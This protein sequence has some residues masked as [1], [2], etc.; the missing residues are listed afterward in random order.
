[1]KMFLTF[2]VS[3]LIIRGTEQ[4]VGTNCFILNPGFL[5]SICHTAF[6]GKIE[7]GISSR[8]NEVHL[9]YTLSAINSIVT[10]FEIHQQHP[11]SKAISIDVFPDPLQMITIIMVMYKTNI[12]HE[13]SRRSNDKV[14]TITFE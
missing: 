11:P 12:K 13:N 10:G 2:L 14:D 3:T 6:S 4:D 1:M 9:S 7:P 8:W 5:C